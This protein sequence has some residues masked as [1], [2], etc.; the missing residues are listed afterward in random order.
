MFRPSILWLLPFARQS[1]CLFIVAV[2][3]R[4]AAQIVLGAYVHPITWEYEAIANS[5]LVGRGYTYDV[6]QTPYVAAVSSPLYVLLTAG[7]YAITAHSHAVMLVLQALL[8]GITASLA[9]WLA[10]RAFRSEAGWAAG[11]LVALDPALLVYSAELHPLS[12]DALAFLVVICTCIALPARPRWGATV[13]VGLSLGLAALTRTTVLS[14]TPVVLLWAN[15]FRSLRLLSAASMALVGA[16]IVVYSPWPIRNSL[17][18]GQFVPG[19]SE[20]TEWLWRGTNPNATGSSFT[21][22]GRTML[23]AAPADFQT[24]IGA[25][26]EAQRIGIYRDAAV[27]Y[28][29]QHPLDAGRLYLLKLKAFWLGSDTT[30]Q[31]YPAAWTPLYETWLMVVLLLGLYGLSVTWRAPSSR[32]TALLIVAAL[33]LVSA[34]QAVFYVEGRHRLAVEPLLLVLAGVGLSQA[35]LMSRRPRID[36]LQLRRARNDLRRN[37][38]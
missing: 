16:A 6:G 18:M 4:L 31:E 28:V 34:T 13:L 23:E 15:R 32:S 1:V 11:L 29:Q 35:V 24:Q 25:A 3:A 26:S 12:Q 20:S 38:A 37:Q 21:G 10:T 19:S 5:I 30:G 7:V 33:V 36:L 9:G 27:T 17:L 14:L 2:A 8:G 22:D